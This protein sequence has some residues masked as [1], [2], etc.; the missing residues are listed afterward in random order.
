MVKSQW[1]I[2]YFIGIAAM[3]DVV[4]IG[5]GGHAKVV[6]DIVLS[7]RDH[8]VGFLTNDEGQ[9]DFMGWPVLGKDTEYERFADC[10]F[11][12]AIGNPGVRERISQSMEGVNWYTAIHPSASISAIH[13]SIGGGSVIM[14]NAV[15]NPYAQ[16]GRHCIINSNAT[17]EHDNQIEDFVHIS[18][19]AELAGTVR[20]GKRT[21]IGAGATVSNGIRV[22]ED[23]MIGAGAV[24]VRNIE[25]PGTYVGIPAHQIK[26]LQA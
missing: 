21:W 8:L 2:P 11:V 22:C 10:C 23:C 26:S 7:S 15:V 6:A 18:V 9:S 12:I 5:T 4:I 25:V 20:V 3:K 24:V 14:A 19:G 1:N 13:T 17:V 16:I